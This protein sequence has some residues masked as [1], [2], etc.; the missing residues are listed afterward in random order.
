MYVP[1]PKPEAMA[2]LSSPLVIIPCSNSLSPFSQNNYPISSFGN[3][4][5]SFARNGISCKATNSDK[6]P[7]DDKNPPLTNLDRRN[8]LIGLGGLYGVAGL[9][10]PFAFAKPVAPPD[11]SK[12]GAAD[13]PP[14]AQQTNCC[15]PISDKIVDFTFPSPSPLRVRPAAHAVDQAYIDKYSKAIELMKALPD[16][17]PRSFTQQADIHCAYCN[18][19]YD[20]VGFPD[21]EL[22]I[23]QSWLFFPF[24]RYY[25]YFYERILGK[26][27]GDPTFALPFWNWDSP[28]GMKLPALF[29]DPS[30]SLYDELRNANHQPPTLL[31]LDW[32]GTDVPTTEADQISSNL[33]IMYRQMVSN[34]KKQQLFFGQAYRAGTDPDPGAGSIETTPHGPVH[35]WTGDNTQPNSEDMGN[36]YSAARD[37]IFFSHH[38]NVDR[39]WSVWKTLGKNKDITDK[40]WLDTGFLFYDENA[41]L[42]RVKVRDCLDSKKLG[43]VYQD[44]DIPW[45]TS[46]PTPRRSKLAK[47]AKAVGVARAATSGPKVVG[48]GDF[49]IKLDSK[50][51][52][53]VTRPKQKKRNK[54]EKE[55]EEEILVIGG[56]Q[57]EKDTA[58]KFDVYVNDLEDDDEPS[59]PDDSEFAGSFVNVPHKHQGKNKKKKTTSCLRLGLTDLLED[60]GAEDDESV[61]VTLVPRYGT[62]SLKIGSVKIEFLAD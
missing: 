9:G 33:K 61:V 20:Q 11:L 58:V 21:L 62:K 4:R 10:D 52:T 53:V 6:N 13:L 18:G 1:K 40:D 26:L 48:R 44:V 28:P 37:P 30:S 14:G 45:L 43:Y 54:K 23:H 39:M 46:R 8:V 57:F 2:S 36:F 59:R 51:S 3:R 35:I 60:L 50:I 38:S 31:D 55:D 41:Q 19:A 34:A 15:P 12:C 17:D 32:N 27:I 47:I 5:H 16:S 22:Q 24:H 49:P 42:V 7:R 25:L 29:A 56:I